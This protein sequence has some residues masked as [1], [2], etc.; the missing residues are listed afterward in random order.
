MNS[1][2]ILLLIFFLPF[3]YFFLPAANFEKD[4]STSQVEGVSV[5]KDD[6]PLSPE[7]SSLKGSL[8]NADMAK[9]ENYGGS[10]LV[11]QRKKDYW[12]TKIFATSSVVIDVD[13]GTILHYDNGRE[14]IPIASLTKMMTAIIVME[15]VKNLDEQVTIDEE[16][17]MTDGTKV[18][19]PRSGYCVNERLHEGEKVTAKD[20][21]MAMLLNSANDAAVALGNHIAGSQKGFAKL[22]NE[23]A[24]DL[25]LGDSKFCNPSGLD[26]DDCYSSAYDLARI[27]AYSMRYDLIWNIMK[28]P[29]VE[30]NSCDGKYS[31]L[32]KNTDL[33]IGQMSN[34]I[35]GK[36]GF[37]YNAGKSLMMAAVD[38]ETRKHKIVAV[39]L[40]DNNRWEDMAGLISWTYDN[41]EWK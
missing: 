41:Y 25:N 34:C 17:I 36:T 38:P 40:N 7:D 22:M 6:F 4:N 15:K 10:G 3:N 27:A 9:N 8:K 32:L 30:I 12:N 24:E 16:A 29:E 33:L 19:C 20:L 21:L 37:T 39:I 23:K 28:M 2:S 31:H 5:Q 11:P 35:G 13:T 14:K 26:E 18:G 1:I